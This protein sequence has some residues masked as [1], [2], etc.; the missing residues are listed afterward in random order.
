[1]S[2]PLGPPI[3]FDDDEPLNLSPALEESLVDTLVTKCENLQARVKEL[4][5]KLANEEHDHMG[6]LGQ[7][8]LY[9]DTADD[10]TDAISKHFG[11]DFGEHSSAN[12]PWANALEFIQSLD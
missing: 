6:T 11:Q 2:L 7:R 12:S 8:D 10:L 5:D 1:M 3:H 9:H 4:E